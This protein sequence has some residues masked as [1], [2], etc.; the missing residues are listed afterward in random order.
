V[1]DSLWIMKVWPLSG[2]KGRPYFAYAYMA[3]T[4]RELIEIY[5]G[6]NSSYQIRH[7]E[8]R[9]LCVKIKVTEVNP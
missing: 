7:R 3:K 6:Y 5:D 2:R 8:G 4:R 9:V 1:T